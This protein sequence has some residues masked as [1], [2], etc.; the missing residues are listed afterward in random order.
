MPVLLLKV[1]IANKLAVNYIIRFCQCQINLK[2]WKDG[3]ALIRVMLYY[4]QYEIM[5]RRRN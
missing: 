5:Q 1:K 4:I 3:L 2:A